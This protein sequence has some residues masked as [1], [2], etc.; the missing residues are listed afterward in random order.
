MVAW[1]NQASF[2]GFSPN[3]LYLQSPHSQFSYSHIILCLLLV[4]SGQ[5][6]YIIHL[7]S[8]APKFGH[9][10]PSH[11]T[12][13]L[14]VKEIFERVRKRIAKMLQVG[15]CINWYQKICT[16]FELGTQCEPIQG[17]WRCP[18]RSR[19]RWQL[20]W[21]ELST[22]FR[23]TTAGQDEIGVVS[24]RWSSGPQRLVYLSPPS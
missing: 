23:D 5:L 13:S 7:A 4:L 10:L 18:W 21:H 3:S 14:D 6:R 22:R 19:G 9:P 11:L 1:E 16:Y 12:V 24:F 20:F 17:L 8:L 2:F 15:S